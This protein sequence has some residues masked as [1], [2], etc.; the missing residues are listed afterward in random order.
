[1]NIQFKSE[2]EQG[3]PDQSYSSASLH[4]SVSV[5][6]CVR[7][8]EGRAKQL[9]PVYVHRKVREGRNEQ[10]FLFMSAILKVNGWDE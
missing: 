3:E 1:M 8:R 4:Y 10:S 5:H 9:H 7:V 6:M 2:V